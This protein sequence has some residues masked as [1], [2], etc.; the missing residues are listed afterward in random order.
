MT[1]NVAIQYITKSNWWREKKI[2][3]HQSISDETSLNWIVISMPQTKNV[4]LTDYF[5]KTYN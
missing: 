1:E 5:I 4:F 3:L 2:I